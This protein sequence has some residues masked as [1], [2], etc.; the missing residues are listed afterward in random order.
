[1][2]IPAMDKDVYLTEKARF[3]NEMMIT[4]ADE[5][6][7]LLTKNQLMIG[8]IIELEADNEALRKELAD[9]KGTISFLAELDERTQKETQA[10]IDQLMYENKRLRARLSNNKKEN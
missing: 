9:A 3:L 4:Q 6:S 10:K 8:R 1:M 5:Y 2:S 7:L